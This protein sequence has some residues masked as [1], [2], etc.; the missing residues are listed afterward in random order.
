MKDKIFYVLKIKLNAK[1][2]HTE[3]TGVMW[4]ERHRVCVCVGG[5][6]EFFIQIFFSLSFYCHLS[7]SINSYLFNNIIFLQLI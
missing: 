5:A 2:K 3:T 7:F 4:E 6:S 1:K